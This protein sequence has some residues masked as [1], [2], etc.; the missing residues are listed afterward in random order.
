MP[1][2]MLAATPPRRTSQVVRE[3]GQRDLVELLDDERVGEPAREGHQV[4]GGDGSGDGD[5]A[6]D[7]NLPQ[8]R[9]AAASPTR[10]PTP[11]E[12]GTPA[13]QECRPV[14]VGARRE[15]RAAVS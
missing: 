14:A 3:E 4:V 8:R 10:R 2:A 6:P 12:A 9:T 13:V 7:C 11:P 15:P 1:K 5:T